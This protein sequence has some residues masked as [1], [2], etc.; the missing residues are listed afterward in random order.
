MKQVLLA[1]V[2]TL[3]LSSVACANTKRVSEEE[4]VQ[5]MRQE[6]ARLEAQCAPAKG[7]SRKEV[8]KK[9]GVGRPVFLGKVPP[10]EGVSEDSP[11]RSYKFASLGTLFVSYDEQWK[12]LRAAFGNPFSTKGRTAGRRV[13][14]EEQ[15]QEVEPRLEQMRRI[16]KECNKRFKKT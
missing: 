4:R 1:L 11:Q 16:V 15:R 6:I 2:L 10:K 14:I 3:I 13:P 5:Q 9:F 12:V 8:E 7:T